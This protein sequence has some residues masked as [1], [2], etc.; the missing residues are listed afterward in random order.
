MDESTL[1]MLSVCVVYSPQARTVMECKLTLPQG[2]TVADALQRS[3]MGEIL[4]NDSTHADGLGVWGRK[5]QPTQV[6]SEGDRVEIYRPLRVDPKVAR[7]E[8]FQK[9]GARSAGLFAK[10][11]DNAK[12]GY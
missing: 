9:Q 8:R 1:A 12:P 7:R 4:A 11:R 6:L 2:A 3:G 10:R 5:A